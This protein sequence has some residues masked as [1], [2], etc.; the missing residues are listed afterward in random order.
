MSIQRATRFSIHRLSLFRRSRPPAVATA[1]VSVA[2]ALLVA[3]AALVAARPRPP[4]CDPDNGGLALAKEYCAKV[5]ASG[6]G[7][8]RQ[9]AVAPNG[10]VYA[11]VS[12]N[13]RLGG[14]G[15]LALRDRDGDGV[16]E[17]RATFG[18]EGGND[19]QLRGNYLYLALPDRVLRFALAGG[20]LAP[21]G[22]EEVV[23]RG[24]PSGGGH[25]AKSVAFG[26]GDVMYV[27]VG[28]ATN[29]CQ[30]RDRAA[31]SPGADPCRELGSR[32]GIWRFSATRLGQRFADGTRFATGL[33]NAIAIEV[34]P[35]TG[36]LWAAIH[37][38]DQ[39]SA[40]WGF[41]D[42]MS[43]E[44]PAEE[45]VQVNAGDDFGWP[46]CYYSVQH[47]KKVLA[48]EYGG[49]GAKV[50]RC[51]AAKAP[52]LAFPAH[53]APMALAFA[54]GGVYVA[55]HGSWNRAP[56]P[57]AGY[58]VVFAPFEG[59][60]PTGRYSTFAIGAAGPT[61]LRAS[62]VAVAPD[63]AVYVSADGNGK[64]WRITKR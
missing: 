21:A 11:A 41:S 17:E 1:R 37:G 55:F 28:S 24:L 2:T 59:D 52:A 15:V 46:Y 44:N 40:S 30:K 23:V 38:R 27:S 57:Q 5:V 8:V 13:G 36:K 29:S 25:V 33:R 51:A 9:I 62:G 34:H 14:R 54:E 26:P 12:G 16:P 7:A 10:D 56:L 53:W 60:K 39:L 63:G 19:V 43:A 47:R 58:R 45:L 64:I 32:A 6:V 22:A 61:A 48:P 35:R 31:R 3:A 4:V 18:P 49:D 42:E 50:G 20:K